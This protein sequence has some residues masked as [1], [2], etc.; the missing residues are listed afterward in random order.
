MRSSRWSVAATH[1]C[2][3]S[4]STFRPV[5]ICVRIGSANPETHEYLYANGNPVG[6]NAVGVDGK[7]SIVLDA[8]SYALNQNLSDSIPGANLSYTVKAGDTLQG[9]AGQMYGNPSLWF[10]IA[11]AN[12]LSAGETLKAGTQLIIPNSIQS[13]TIT[14]DNHKVYSEG[15]IVGSTLP[16]LK[17][18]PPPSSGGGCGSILAIIIIVVIAVMVAVVTERHFCFRGVTFFFGPRSQARPLFKL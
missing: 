12:G 18:P 4:V 8:G 16:N 5:A 9:I 3:R 1:Q 6:E 10:V 2:P 14:A 13:G 7:K 15:E 11:E 17:S